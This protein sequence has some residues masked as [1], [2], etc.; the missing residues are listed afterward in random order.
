MNEIK[1]PKYTRE[2]NLACKLS[3]K[4][5]SEIQIRKKNGE[6]YKQIAISYNVTQQ[7]VYYWCL[8]EEERKRRT[9]L[10]KVVSHNDPDKAR[11][12]RER[13][14]ELRP[15]YKGY[16]NQ[17]DY[18]YK[19]E[20]RPNYKETTRKSGHNRWLKYKDKII[21]YNKKYQLSHLD[22]FKEYNKKHRERHIDKVRQQSRE[23][24]QRHR[25][26]KLAHDRIM[27]RKK[28]PIVMRKTKYN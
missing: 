17:F 21:K 10:R 2:E 5:I 15:E 9:A 7:T 27:Y 22:K 11:E 1:Y 24:Y 12:W 13:K 20:N 26:R 8:D 6:S 4:Q 14:M 18:E 28:H 19:K 25:E 3:D 23:S 16:E